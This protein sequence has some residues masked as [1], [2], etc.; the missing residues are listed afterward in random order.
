MKKISILLLCAI[1]ASSGALYSQQ[2]SFEVQTAHQMLDSMRSLNLEYAA[3]FSSSENR[4]KLR[5]EVKS[6]STILLQLDSIT[7]PDNYRVE[8][9]YDGEGKVIL[10]TQYV[11]NPETSA[12]GLGMK[13]EFS[14]DENMYLIERLRQQWNPLADGW[15]NQALDE[16]EF[17]NDGNELLSQ[18]S[19]W[20]VTADGWIATQRKE[21]TF[22]EE[23][24]LAERVDF[25]EEAGP[26]SALAPQFKITYTYDG[27]GLTAETITEIRDENEPGVEIWIPLRQSLYS[28][29]NGLQDTVFINAWSA[30]DEEWRISQIRTFEYDGELEILSLNEA[31]N[32][33]EEVWTG[34]G[35]IERE[36]T[37]SGLETTT[38]H[39]TMD[40]AGWRPVF[41]TENIF[42]AGDNAEQI[43][44]YT[45][46]ENLQELFLS[47]S[48]Q[49][50]FDLGYEI[51]ELAIPHAYQNTP[52]IKNK[53][54]SLSL[55]GYFPG[56]VI[57][58]QIDDD[59]HYSAFSSLSTSNTEDPALRLYPNPA[60]D[61]I[62]ISSENQTSRARLELFDLQG[63]QLMDKV[64]RTNEQISITGIPQGLYIYRLNG[65][66]EINHT[67]KLIKH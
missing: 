44:L 45:W 62:N 23:G 30:D 63:R 11:Y 38:A 41:T 8:Y 46:S 55:T 56:G 5:S 17:D 7:S 34:T 26:G 13:V 21:Q 18:S 40:E 33:I 47:S 27:S 57:A 20:S 14:Y 54:E 65:G 66:S 35:K 58:S 67:G 32:P 36:Y 59:F 48:A 49:Y 39:Y 28:Y 16:F 53:P 37:T 19:F 42:G 52:R 22:D 25:A 64:T 50:S 4:Q 61:F 1:L 29:E 10:E 9:S 2:N 31:W 60:S 15:E 51:D 24:R 12:Y 43:N 3:L 6:A